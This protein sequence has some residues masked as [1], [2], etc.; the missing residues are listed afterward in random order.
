MFFVGDSFVSTFHILAVHQLFIYTQHIP[1]FR[2]ELFRNKFHVLS[3]HFRTCTTFRHCGEIRRR[4]EH[5]RF[6]DLRPHCRNLQLSRWN[7]CR[8][9]K[10]NVP[11]RY[12]KSRYD[13]SCICECVCVC[14]SVH[15]P[16]YVCGRFVIELDKKRIRHIQIDLCRGSTAESHM[17]YMQWHI[18][19]HANISKTIVDIIPTAIL[20]CR[21]ISFGNYIHLWFCMSWRCISFYIFV[22]LFSLLDFL[23]SFHL[24]F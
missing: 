3:G 19:A 20:N 1:V 8:L 15:T 14:A 17:D 11:P 4:D 16:V 10:P 23:M 24:S 18:I 5:F 6:T 2:A 7:R 12:Y 22:P 9:T 13:L 21:E